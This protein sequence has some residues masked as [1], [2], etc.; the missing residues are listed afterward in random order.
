MKRSPASGWAGSGDSTVEKSCPGW[1]IPGLFSYKT[2][3]E[4][5][6]GDEESISI[7]E[8]LLRGGIYQAIHAST[9]GE[10]VRS[11]L[12]RIK[13][14]DYR[15]RYKEL[16]TSIT[17]REALCP[18]SVGNGIALPHP[19]S[20]GKFTA[21]SYIALCR[22]ERPIPFGAVDNEDV[23]TLF[24]IFPKNE[25]RFLRIQAKLL[26]LLR[27][28]RLFR[29]L[30]GCSFQKSYTGARY[31]GSWQKKRR[32]S[33]GRLTYDVRSDFNG[34]RI[35]SAAFRNGDAGAPFQEHQQILITMSFALATVASFLGVT[36][37]IWSVGSGI[38]NQVILP[39]GLPDL[40][41]HLRLDALS[42]FFL[43]VIGLLSLF[44]SVYSIGYIKGYLGQR[45]VTSLIIFYCIFIAGMMMVVLAD[46]ALCFLVSWR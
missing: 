6:A 7:A 20:F 23:D 39:I 5:S 41:F 9:K 32:R 36:A 29:R 38:T 3:I 11:S 19:G 21:S 34:R 22:L 43:T 35:S 18:T 24:F 1:K 37:G 10:A 4:N 27:K 31:C 45:S 16:F 44:V 12:E 26:R 17:D 46:D 30:D 15:Y 2:A 14:A 40:P 13:N 33:S 8:F 25:R 28:K 42:G